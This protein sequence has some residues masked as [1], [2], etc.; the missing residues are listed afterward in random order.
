MIY[1]KQEYLIQKERKRFWEMLKKKKNTENWAPIPKLNFTPN[2]FKQN[3]HFILGESD[4]AIEQR[5]ANLFLLKII[6]FLNRFSCLKF[7]SQ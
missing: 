4:V 1:S 6:L 3:F 7:I 5:D 2:C